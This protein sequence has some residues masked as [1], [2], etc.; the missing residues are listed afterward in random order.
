MNTAKDKAQP[1]L[2]RRL[3]RKTLQPAYVGSVNGSD[4]Y[5]ISEG[6]QRE[7]L[8]GDS[9]VVVVRSASEFETAVESPHTHTLFVPSRAALTQ[10]IAERILERNPLSKTIFWEI[11]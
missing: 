5:Q 10:E 11:G 2:L 1:E 6:W 4:I 7:V 8:L 9:D 3:A